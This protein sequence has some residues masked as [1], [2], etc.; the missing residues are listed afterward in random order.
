MD[1]LDDLKSLL[2]KSRKEAREEVLLGLANMA[3]EVEEMVKD[4]MVKS[5][6][7]EWGVEIGFHAIPSMKW[8]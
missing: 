2:M 7:F 3:G 4:E 5:E 1:M 8:V 6:G